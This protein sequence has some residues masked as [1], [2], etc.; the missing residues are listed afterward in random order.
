VRK[1]EVLVKFPLK[2]EQDEKVR[3]NAEPLYKKEI[4]HD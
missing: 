4:L 1:K 3:I 2:R